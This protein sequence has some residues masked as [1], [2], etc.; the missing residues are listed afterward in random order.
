MSSKQVKEQL[1]NLLAHNWEEEQKE[2]LSRV[3]ENITYYNRFIPKTM[4]E[5]I[6]A[7]L[8]LAN[9]LKAE[10]DDLKK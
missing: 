3:F 4:K 2:L 1:D 6:L 5:D 7:V 8:L 9:G 10:L